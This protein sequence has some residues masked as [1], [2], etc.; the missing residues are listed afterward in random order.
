MYPLE[1][2]FVKQLISL[3]DGNYTE[4][5]FWHAR[6]RKEF[7]RSSLQVVEKDSK[8]KVA[9]RDVVC[10]RFVPLRRQ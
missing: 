3:C 4:L 9:V 10:V 2:F 5:A 8:G 1:E 7:I 6:K